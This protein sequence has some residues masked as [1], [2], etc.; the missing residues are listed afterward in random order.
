MSVTEI[1]N[2]NHTIYLYYPT[3]NQHYKYFYISII[4]I[5]IIKFYGIVNEITITKGQ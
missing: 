4:Q 1:T 2:L 3:W 5:S